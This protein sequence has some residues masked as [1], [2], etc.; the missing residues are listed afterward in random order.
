MAIE[1]RRAHLRLGETED[2]ETDRPLSQPG[3]RA[4]NPFLSL[5]GTPIKHNP[6][7]KPSLATTS[8]PSASVRRV[9]KILVDITTKIVENDCSD[10]PTAQKILNHIE[11]V[12]KEFMDELKKLKNKP[13]AKKAEREKKVRILMSM[14]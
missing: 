10:I 7:P 5:S 12:E 6:K 3:P 4:P 11:S 1:G 13:S 8:S 2:R 9:R 14:R